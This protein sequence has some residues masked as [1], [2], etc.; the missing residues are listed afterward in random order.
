MK[1]GIGNSN[2]VNALACLVEGPGAA[3]MQLMEMLY[4]ESVFFYSYGFGKLNLFMWIKVIFRIG[5]FHHLA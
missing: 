1:E 4:P 3:M 2:Q 5:L